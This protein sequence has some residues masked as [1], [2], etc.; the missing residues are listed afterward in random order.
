MHFQAEMVRH[1]DADDAGCAR[2]EFGTCG[3]GGRGATAACHQHPVVRAARWLRNLQRTDTKDWASEMNLP[4]EMWKIFAC[5]ALQLYIVGYIWLLPAALYRDHCTWLLSSNEGEV[6]LLCITRWCT[7]EFKSMQRIMEGELMVALV[8]KEADFGWFNS[9]MWDRISWSRQTKQDK[10]C[11]L[12][13]VHQTADQQEL[14]R[15]GASGEVA[16]VRGRQFGT[17]VSSDLDCE[18]SSET[19]AIEMSIFDL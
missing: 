2:A 17:S 1:D 15:N 13:E 8:E 6:G 9:V 11:A 7:S 14:N 4:A 10:F 5:T 12:G 16:A 18:R 3:S 19:L